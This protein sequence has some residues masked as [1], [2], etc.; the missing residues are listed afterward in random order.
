MQMRDDGG[1]DAEERSFPEFKFRDRGVP[2][3]PGEFAGMRR[4]TDL[5]DDIPSIV[6]SRPQTDV[7]N[8]LNSGPQLGSFNFFEQA[9]A[10]GVGGGA[11]L[12]PQGG[13]PGG[14][15][16]SA[17]GSPYSS[18]RSTPRASVSRLQ[19]MSS[20]TPLS[21][22]TTAAGLSLRPSSMLSAPR[23][24]G[25]SPDSAADQ[26]PRAALRPALPLTR[27]PPNVAGGPGRKLGAEKKKKPTRQQVQ[28]RMVA[29]LDEYLSALDVAEACTCVAELAAPRKLMP[30]LVSEMVHRSLE[31]PA[32]QLAMSRLLAA[33][34]AEERVSSEDFLEALD[35]L[36][37]AR[38]DLALDVPRVV[39]YLGGFC[40]RA[41]QDGVLTLA[42]LAPTFA[43]GLHTPVLVAAL[44][45]QLR[46]QGEAALI[47]A[48]DAARL[49][50]MA[51][52]P[53]NDRNVA[54]LWAL[55]QSSGLGC[56]QPLLQLDA[57]LSAQIVAA[58]PQ[59]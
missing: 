42:Q 19:P 44:Q 54:A 36:L 50:V 57:N 21:M 8:I 1:F 25:A 27:A 22:P 2:T 29:L 13:F 9:Q 56:L 15:S 16:G 10:G 48:C 23:D 51:A 20:L 12:R 49:D 35:E 53:Q 58:M 11:N 45:H 6:T 31:A 40:H 7:S 30:L 39:E 5:F 28:E 14:P 59:V 33:L 46:E 38:T 3:M 4:T 24:Y 41:V 32:Q 34:V 52:L 37:D 55:L 26:A 18:G 47:A 43:S 17:G